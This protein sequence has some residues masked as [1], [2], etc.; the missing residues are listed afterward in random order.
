M[1]TLEKKA[2]LERY[3]SLGVTTYDAIDDNMDYSPCYLNWISDE[4]VDSYVWIGEG[5]SLEKAAAEIYE[6]VKASLFQ[7]CNK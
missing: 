4:D 5:D 7:G 2:W 6:D 1:D 3:G